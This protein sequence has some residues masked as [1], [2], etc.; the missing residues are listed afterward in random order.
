MVRKG[1]LEPPWA[2]PLEPKSS[3]STNS[4]TFAAAFAKRVI[5]ADPGPA[6]PGERPAATRRL[7]RG[8]VVLSAHCAR[9]RV[10]V[11]HYE[12]F[13][14]ASLLVPSALRPADRRD[15]PVRA[16]GRRHR[17][18]RR[19]SSPARPAWPRSTATSVRST[20]SQRARRRAEPPFPRA[21]GRDRAPRP[22]AG[23]VPR[24]PVGVPAGRDR[25]RATPTAELCS[26]TAAARPI[27]IGRLML[28]LYR[29]R[30][31]RRIASP[32]TRSA[33]RSS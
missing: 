30:R 16:H 4:A 20:P 13:P 17:R 2:V 9:F 6:T 33:R 1:G 31:R 21:R 22:A 14:V 15:L 10:S 32:A 19:R 5:I 25:R 29:C 11:A 3:A 27:P 28:R 7:C 24:S 26:T 12:N 18:R 23:A 8:N